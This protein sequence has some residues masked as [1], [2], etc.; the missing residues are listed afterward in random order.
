MTPAPERAT[1]GSGTRMPK[2]LLLLLLLWLPHGG[3]VLPQ[4][5]EVVYVEPTWSYTEGEDDE[6]RKGTVV[7]APIK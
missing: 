7:T 1:Q 2:Q 6:G 4:R 5:E 3:C